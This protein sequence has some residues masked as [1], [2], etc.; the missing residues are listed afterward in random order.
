MTY[1]KK[2]ATLTVTVVGDHGI[3]L[4]DTVDDPIASM[5]YANIKAGRGFYADIAN[6]GVLSYIS[7]SA[8]LTATI[9]YEDSD[10]IEKTDPFCVEIKKDEPTDDCWWPYMQFDRGFIYVMKD[11]WQG[12]DHVALELQLSAGIGPNIR[13]MLVSGQALDSSDSRKIYLNDIVSQLSDAQFIAWT[14][15]VQSGAVT[16]L[17]ICTGEYR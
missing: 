8:V 2:L 10:P 5:A 1:T 9:A 13:T 7:S 12:D 6:T 4:T 15:A 17:N 14:N 16:E 11:E 3:T